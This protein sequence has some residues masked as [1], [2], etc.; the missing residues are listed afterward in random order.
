MFFLFFVFFC[1]LLRHEKEEARVEKAPYSL[2]NGGRDLQTRC[3]REM[4]QI[5]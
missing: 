5:D 3:E 1:Q 2:E 4:L